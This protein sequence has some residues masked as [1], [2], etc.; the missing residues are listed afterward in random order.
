VQLSDAAGDSVERAFGLTVVGTSGEVEVVLQ[1]GVMDSGQYGYSYGT[2]Q[3]RSG[4]YA[5]FLGTGV[6][7]ALHVSGYDIDDPSGDEVEVHLNGTFL[8][9][10]SNGPDNGMNAGDVFAIPVSL[11]QPGPNLIYFKQKVPGWKWGVTNLLLTP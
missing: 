8:G 6:D 1:I 11:Q 10:L 7:L 9:Y 5:T 2:S 3:H 4:L